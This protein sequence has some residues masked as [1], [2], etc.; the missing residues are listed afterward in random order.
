MKLRPTL[1]LVAAVCLGGSAQAQ[2]IAPGLWEHTVTMKMTGMEAA[3]AQMKEQ[4][5]RMPPEQRKR[6]EEMMASRGGPGAAGGMGMMSGQPT[7][8]KVCITAEQA[9]RDEI[10]QHDANC[11]QTSKE[12]SGKT[13]KFK[14][15]CTGE[16]QATGEGEFTLISD[17]EHKG[18]VVVDAV[19]RGKPMHIEMD[20]AGRWLAADC[21][22][23]KPRGAKK[24]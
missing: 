19:S 20:N 17:K 15:A 1:L 24:P 4:M 3:Q 16:R 2:K 22:E 8:V 5:D 11:Q 7:T 10:P 23:V 6:M 12:R 14:F 9:A 21:G 13:L 18:H